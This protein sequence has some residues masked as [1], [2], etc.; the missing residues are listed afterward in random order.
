MPDPHCGIV[1][2]VEQAMEEL[3]AQYGKDEEEE[4]HHDGHVAHGR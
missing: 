2:A 3:H 1:A 4:Q